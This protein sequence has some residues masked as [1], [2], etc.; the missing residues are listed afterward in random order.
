MTNANV[1]HKEKKHQKHKSCTE[2]NN[3]K[4]MKQA[5]GNKRVFTK[6]TQH[7]QRRHSSHSLIRESICNEVKLGSQVAQVATLRCEMCDPAVSDSGW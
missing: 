2:V 3:Y 5:S 4:E 7:K 6:T 1:E